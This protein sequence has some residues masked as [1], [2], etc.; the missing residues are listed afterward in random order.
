M[1]LPNDNEFD[2]IQ[3]KQVCVTLTTPKN[4]N[5]QRTKISKPDGIEFRVRNKQGCSVAWAGYLEWMEKI[6]SES[7]DGKW[8]ENRTRELTCQ[9]SVK[10]DDDGLRKKIAS[11]P[12]KLWIRPIP[13]ALF[14]DENRR[15]LSHLR[16]AKRIEIKPSDCKAL[17]SL[18]EITTDQYVGSIH[19]ETS[20]A[21]DEIR[22]LILVYCPEKRAYDGVIPKDQQAYI[23][24]L[25]RAVSE[26]KNRVMTRRNSAVNKDKVYP[27]NK[28]VQG[29]N[30]S[31]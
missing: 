9:I 22:T 16:G 14:Q 19:L 3:Q 20:D 27:N 5:G 28:T 12:S 6:K 24:S 23:D 10:S 4:S 8:I 21:K 29:Q 18:L 11:W 17:Q 25:K 13:K 31:R 2:S 15:I 1:T 30:N 7:S 26:T